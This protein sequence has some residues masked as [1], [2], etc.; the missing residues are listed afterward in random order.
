M[1]WPKT[2]ATYHAQLV[3]PDKDHANTPGVWI[4]KEN[5]AS[6]SYPWLLELTLSCH[7]Q[8]HRP[9]EVIC[10]IQFSEVSVESTFSVEKICFSKLGNILFNLVK[11]TQSIEQCCK[12]VMAYISFSL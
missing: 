7:V 5:I 12:S 3:H 1:S 8:Q 6:L 2:G 11:R 4:E 10:L 9:Y